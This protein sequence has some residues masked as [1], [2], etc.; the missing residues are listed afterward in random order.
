MLAIAGVISVLA[1]LI[2][3]LMGNIPNLL[4]GY[5]RAMIGTATQMGGLIYMA[6]ELMSRR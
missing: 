4:A 2:L 6:M 5:M 3:V 1:L